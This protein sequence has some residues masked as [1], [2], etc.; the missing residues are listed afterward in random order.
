MEL[1]YDKNP[2]YLAK[3]FFEAIQNGSKH[4]YSRLE[5]RSIIKFFLEEKCKPCEMYRRMCDV[6]G[7]ACFNSRILTNE[8]NMGLPLGTCAE[9]T[10]HEVKT[11]WHSGKVKVSA[12]VPVR[13]DML[14]VF[15]DMKETNTI[16][17]L[18]KV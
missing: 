10:V 1:L 11:Y 2:F 6:Y 13:R 7:K 9:K 16:D 15:W 4:E 14:A 5:Q 8:L 12:A 17:F 3:M 18:E